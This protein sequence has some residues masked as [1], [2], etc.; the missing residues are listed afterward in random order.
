MR[1][2]LTHRRLV[3]GLLYLTT[4]L[5]MS[6]DGLIVVEKA[7][8]VDDYKFAVFTSLE[9]QF[10]KSEIFQG[11]VIYKWAH[12]ADATTLEGLKAN[13]DFIIS[14][15]VQKID[16]QIHI[17]INLD[18]KKI[19]E[20]K[21]WKNAFRDVNTAETWSAEIASDAEYFIR[22][23]GQ[24]RKKISVLHFMLEKDKCNTE[25][26]KRTEHMRFKIPKN[27][28]SILHK[29]RNKEESI[30]DFHF[31]SLP[32]GYE[33][34]ADNPEYDGALHGYYHIKDKVLIVAIEFELNETCQLQ[35]IKIAKD[36][37]TIYKILGEAAVLSISDCPDIID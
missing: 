11:K 25:I 22:K 6:Q 23:N 35:E 14:V 7:R 29:V 19:A 27:L 9:N 37:P 5:G 26:D 10:E 8:D 2:F 20:K 30:S 24:E 32:K 18:Y 17:S 16:G 21:L 15:F 12:A 34:Y 28:I 4:F 1:S 33:D 36:H 13:T 3:F 31:F